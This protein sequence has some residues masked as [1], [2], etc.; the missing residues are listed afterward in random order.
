M[1]NKELILECLSED[2]EAFTQIVEYFELPPARN[3]SRSEIID[4]LEEMIEEGYVFINYKWKTENNEYPFSLTDAGKEA[5]KKFRISW[6]DFLERYLKC[7]HEFLLK[8]NGVEY[9]LAFHEDNEKIIAEL[10]FG[11]QEAGY[12]R[13]EYSSPG[14]LLESVNIEGKSIQEMWDHLIVE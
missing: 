4:A 8:Y 1:T 14:A 6:D 10:K 3:V 13:S 5:W 9:H 2:D 12:V 7:K 11:T